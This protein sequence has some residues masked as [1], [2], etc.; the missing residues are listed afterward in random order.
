MQSLK[1]IFSVGGGAL[2]NV[3]NAKIIRNHYVLKYQGQQLL[4]QFSV[5]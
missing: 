3:A 1:A 4:K 5:G 2:D